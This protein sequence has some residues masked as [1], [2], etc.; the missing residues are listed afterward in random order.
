M[1]TLTGT[2]R[3]SGPIDLKEGGKKLKLW[4]EHE[5]AR[6]EG[7]PDL[8]IEELLVDPVDDSKL[9]KAGQSVTVEVRPYVAG[10]NVAFSA[11]KLVLQPQPVQR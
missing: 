4:I 1:I 6:R 2:L 10:R 5:S 8:K 9:P 3:Q 7:P 11:V